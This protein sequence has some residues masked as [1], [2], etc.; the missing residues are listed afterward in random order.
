MYDYCSMLSDSGQLGS[1][2]VSTGSAG[3]FSSVP[4]IYQF[5]R[6]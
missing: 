3:D 6:A 4:V 2:D 1:K 5:Y